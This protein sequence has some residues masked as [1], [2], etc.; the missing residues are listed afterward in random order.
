VSPD[1]KYIAFVSDKGGSPQIYTVRREG[2]DVRRITFKGS[3]NTSPSWSP[4]GD[5]IV[6]AG[7]QGTNQIFIV[8]PDGTGLTQLTTRGNNE[9]PSFSPDGRYITFSSDRDGVKGIYI[10]RANGESQKRITPKN[11][12]ASGPRWSPN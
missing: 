7:R 3:Y 11:L 12:R 2:S 9:V 1:G 8:N 10:M 5:R 6:F 4:K